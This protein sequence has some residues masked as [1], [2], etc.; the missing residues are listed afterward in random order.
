MSECDFQWQRLGYPRLVAVELH[1]SPRCPSAGR[2]TA[3]RLSAVG[4]LN[5][6]EPSRDPRGS[7]AKPQTASATS[8]LGTTQDSLLLLSPPAATALRASLFPST[9][10][11]RFRELSGR[12]AGGGRGKMVLISRPSKL[13]PLRFCQH[14]AAQ[15]RPRSGAHG[16]AGGQRQCLSYAQFCIASFGASADAVNTDVAAWKDRRV[17][18]PCSWCLQLRGG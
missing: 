7:A 15:G 1:L 9:W 6:T 8:S 16:H 10:S 4:W 5:F 12:T 17:D 2:Q 11:P 13:N 3:F 14:G 18:E